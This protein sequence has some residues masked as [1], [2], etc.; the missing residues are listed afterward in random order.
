[1]VTAYYNFEKA[2]VF[3]LGMTIYQMITME[4][5][6]G[7]NVNNNRLLNNVSKLRASKWV[8][9][10]LT[11]ML[12]RDYNERFSFKDCL[13]CLDDNLIPEIR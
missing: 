2:D 4:D 10:L 7:L 5:I 11:G 9:S 13:G 1:M 3:S 8:K 6:I 12:H